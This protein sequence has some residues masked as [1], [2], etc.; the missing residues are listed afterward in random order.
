MNQFRDTVE[1][2][3]GCEAFADVAFLGGKT[4]NQLIDAELRGTEYALYRAYCMSQTITLPEVNAYTLA[5]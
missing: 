5:N 3:H 1:I 2:A 4:L